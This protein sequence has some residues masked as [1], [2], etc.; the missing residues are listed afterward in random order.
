MARKTLE[1]RIRDNYE[2]EE[3]AQWVAD[4]VAKSG[5]EEKIEAGELHLPHPHDAKRNMEREKGIKDVPQ[6]QGAKDALIAEQ[7]RRLAE[8]DNRLKA[9][10]AQPKPEAKA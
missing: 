4:A 1:E 10:E 6:D 9:L 3:V 8:M 5:N 2:D 7:S